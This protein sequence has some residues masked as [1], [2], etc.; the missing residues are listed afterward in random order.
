VPF[1]L[2]VFVSKKNHVDRVDRQLRPS[3][4][5]AT[6]LLSLNWGPDGS[7]IAKTSSLWTSPFC[8]GAAADTLSWSGVGC[9]RHVHYLAVRPLARGADDSAVSVR[10]RLALAAPRPSI[11]IGQGT[12]QRLIE[13]PHEM[14]GAGG[15]E[16]LGR[17]CQKEWAFGADIPRKEDR[18]RGT[19][20]SLDR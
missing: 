17:I 7:D 5:L 19:W 1:F 13:L 9:L 12:V 18:N 11:R 14:R 10:T 3:H 6:A 4:G 20:I 8:N 16:C 2:A 15:I